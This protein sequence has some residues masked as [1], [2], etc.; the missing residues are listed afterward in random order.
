MLKTMNRYDENVQIE[1]SNTGLLDRGSSYVPLRDSDR[2]SYNSVNASTFQFIIKKEETGK[3]KLRKIHRTIIQ[4][5]QE[6]GGIQEDPIEKMS[7][8]LG[9]I[10]LSS[11]KLNKV[12]F[13]H[14]T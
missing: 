11:R 10:K 8:I 13:Q 7:S 5:I 12:I 1:T 2:V 3:E 14:N 6:E 9:R 4:E